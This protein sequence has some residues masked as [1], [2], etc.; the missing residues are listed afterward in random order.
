M[1]SCILYSVAFWDFPFMIFPGSVHTPPSMAGE[2]LSEMLK[3][4][5]WTKYRIFR[6]IL[7]QV[8][9]NLV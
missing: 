8:A 2:R 4:Y 9:E 1:A 5:N 3:I 6:M 7:L